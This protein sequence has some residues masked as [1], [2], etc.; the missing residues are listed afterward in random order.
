MK[1]LRERYALVRSGVDSYSG[2]RAAFSGG[3]GNM[4]I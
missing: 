3:T 1:L 4:S 2:N